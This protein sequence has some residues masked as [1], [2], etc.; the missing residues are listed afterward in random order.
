MSKVTVKSIANIGNLIPRVYNN[1]LTV[2]SA[3]PVD[4]I[5]DIPRVLDGAELFD[6]LLPVN[7]S[8][9]MRESFESAIKRLQSDPV[10]ARLLDNVAQQLPVVDSVV[11]LSVDDKLAALRPVLVTGTSFDDEVW[12]N[13]VEDTISS[14]LSRPAPSKEPEP[15]EPAASPEPEPFA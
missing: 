1:S 9:G 12:L 13:Q 2:S 6:T 3:I 10:K 14:Y 5:K 11:G 15:K 4:G 8:T 7:K